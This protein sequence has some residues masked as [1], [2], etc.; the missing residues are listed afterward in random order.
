MGEKLQAME[1]D[2]ITLKKQKQKAN[3]TTKQKNSVKFKVDSCLHRE[4]IHFS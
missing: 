4:L 2:Q 3:K 1:A